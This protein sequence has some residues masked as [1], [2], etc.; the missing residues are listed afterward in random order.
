M[1]PALTVDLNHP[2]PSLVSRAAGVIRDGGI[3][4]FPTDTFY[5]LAADPFNR[6]AVERLFKIKGRDPSKPIL[7]LIARANSLIDLVEDIPPAAEILI[8]RFWPGPLT[9]VFKAS[10]RFSDVLTGSAGKVG[11]RLPHS[12]LATRLIEAA[13]FPLTATSAN[14]SGEPSPT[15][16]QEVVRMLAGSVD[17]ILDGGVCA[18]IPSTVLDVT[19]HPPAI[20]RE[21]RISAEMLSPWLERKVRR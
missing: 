19:C 16:A 20:L 8:G 7:L 10:S 3:V 15:S 13:G 21:G 2:D 1:E 4:A 12:T 18:P 11:I 9:L 5:G 14:L 17:L 6:A